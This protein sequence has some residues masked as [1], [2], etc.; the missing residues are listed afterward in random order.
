MRWFFC[1]C[2]IA[3]LSGLVPGSAQDVTQADAL[4]P[5]EASA[6]LS[7]GWTPPGRVG[8]VSLASGNVDFRLSS[9][10]AW[11]D[12]ELNQP[13]FTGE[14]LRTDPRARTEIRIGAQRID[15]SNGSEIEI[16]SLRDGTTRLLLVRGRIGLQ[17]RN[18]GENETV[19]IAVPQGTL[20]M[21][22]GT[23]DIDVDAEEHPLRVAVFDGKAHLSAAGGDIAIGS[24]QT[25]VI[26]SSGPTD[27]VHTEQA[28]AD[29]FVAWCR[30]RD[31]DETRLAAPYFISRDMTGYEELDSAGTWKI[32]AQY[33]PV[34]FPTQSVEWAPYRFGHWKWITPWGWTW[35]D[36]RPWGFATSHYGRWALIDEHWAWVPG[37]YV[38]HPLYAPAVVAFL[39]TP[40][41]GLSSEEGA[42][43]AWFPLAPG[44][45]FWPSYTRDLDYI[46]NLNV[47]TVHD[48]TSLAMQAD[49]EPPLEIFNEDFANRLFTTAVPRSVFVNGRPVAAAR[50]I[51]PERRLQNAPV[52]MASPQI[53]PASLQRIAR[54]SAPL[55]PITRVGTPLSRKGESKLV[56][57]ASV[58]SRSRAPSV[59]LRG[60][61]LRAPSYAGQPH[62]RQ[63]IVLR[64]AHSRGGPGKKG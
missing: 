29:E 52:L 54:A 46:R 13:I 36:D 22:A 39:G 23:Y 37:N 34:W 63:V 61:H 9:E 49:G 14:A 3:T 30:D 41:I 17:L 12:V 38:E 48:V 57:V 1:V 56:R 51:L 55:P 64:V 35:L 45:A 16:A 24:G 7:S 2:F 53:A 25:A 43:V 58:P 60:A 42:T 19:E 18:S 5:V 62:G 21:G 26:G 32:N 28:S 6:P 8:R 31:A 40:G 47:E 59:I 33:G 4:P 11:A 50:L 20:S 27:A 44:E 15:L 10:T